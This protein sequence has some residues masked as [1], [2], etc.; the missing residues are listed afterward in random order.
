MVASAALGGAA[1]AASG[2][3]DEQVLAA[4]GRGA[5][6][7]TVREAYKSFTKHDMEGKPATKPH[8]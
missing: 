8:C 7:G 4:F 6:V 1:V 5:V 3:S 2:G